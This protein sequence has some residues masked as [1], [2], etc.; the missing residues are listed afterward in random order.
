MKSLKS[1]GYRREE[2]SRVNRMPGKTRVRGFMIYLVMNR[3]RGRLR[4]ISWRRPWVVRMFSGPCRMEMMGTM[5]STLRVNILTRCRG[6]WRA[7]SSRRAET[8]WPP[9]RW[10]SCSRREQG[11]DPGM[12]EAPGSPGPD[13][14]VAERSWAPHPTESPASPKKSRTEPAPETPA[15]APWPSAKAR[16]PQQT[17]AHQPESKRNQ[18]KCTKKSRTPTSKSTG[19]WTSNSTIWIARSIIL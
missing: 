11:L 15:A 13:Q 10:R 14:K 16:R 1:K 4:R 5:T 2:T 8:V 18:K 9:R 19:I 17:T 7:S 6:R 12:A 3:I